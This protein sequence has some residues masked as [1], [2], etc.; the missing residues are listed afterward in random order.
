[1]TFRRAR[2]SALLLWL[3]ACGGGGGAAPDP[4][5][6]MVCSTPPASSCPSATRALRYPATGTCLAVGGAG[7]CDYQPTLQDCTLTGQACDAGACVTP[8]DPCDGVACTTPPAQACSSATELVRYASPGT[9]TATGGA[10]SCDYQPSTE[11]CALA[12]Q[13]CADGACVAPPPC[14]A[15]GV[16]TTPPAD[17]CASATVALQ[18]PG[19]GVCSSPAGTAICEYL[20][21]QVDCALTG[22][23]CQGGGCVAAPCDVA[24]VCTA[25]PAAT[26]ASTTTLLEYPSPGVCTAVDGQASCE[27]PPT[28]VSCPA[29]QLCQGGGCVAA[30]CT[31]PAGG[32]D[33]LAYADLR[34]GDFEIR[35]VRVDGSCDQL[36]GSGP[37][38]D[39]QPWWSATADLLAWTGE[40]DGNKRVVLQPIGGAQRVLDTGPALATGAVLSPDGTLVAFE[41]LAVG[42]FRADVYLVPAAGGTPVA[43]ETPPP[44]SND[45]GPVFSFSAQGNFLYFISDRSGASEIWRV[46]V[47]AAG[48]ATAA[49]EKVTTGSLLVGRPTV[50]AD[51]KL[52]AWA[53]SNGIAFPKVI[54]RDLTTGAERILSDQADSEPAFPAAGPLIAVRTGRFDLS[55]G[56]VVLLDATTG[57]LVN[58]LTDGTATVGS[59]AFPR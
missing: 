14:E 4:C 51:G 7:T 2:A 52:L 25:P 8:P 40:R 31:I 37:G 28:E 5:A 6:G 58:R 13:V 1:M 43:L 11:D 55:H 39:L 30:P 21:V 17:G 33:F 46:A 54:V 36:V 19:T 23:V 12:G 9:C 57:L 48:V 49:P 10:A 24:G 22:L 38:Y 35:A 18:Y 15:G 56:D 59:P 27:Y 32:G 50:S 47:T 16:C 26:C 41:R 20:P 53:S 34:S 3:V 44:A 29:G 45:A 42:A